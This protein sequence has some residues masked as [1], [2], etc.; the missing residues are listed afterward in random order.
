MHYLLHACSH[1]FYKRLN[2]KEGGQLSSSTI[3]LPSPII[4]AV[5]HFSNPLFHL[6][7]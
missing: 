1:A 3:T 5:F 7:S 2:I 4:V 6:T